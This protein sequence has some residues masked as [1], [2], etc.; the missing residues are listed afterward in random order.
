METTS[1]SKK[2]VGRQFIHSCHIRGKFE[3]SVVIKEKIKFD[4]GSVK[5]NIVTI[6]NPRRS[7]YVTNKRYR[8]YTHKPE[9]E[10]LSKL[11]KYT[12]FDYELDRKVAEVL[13]L[14]F[15]WHSR[16]AL[17]KS[18]YIF[19]ADISIE[20][21]IKMKYLR[22]YPNANLQPTTGFLDIETSIDTN[23]IILISYTYDNVVYTAIL[24]S[25]LFENIGNSRVPIKKDELLRHVKENLATRTNG[26]DFTYNIEIFDHEI[27][28]IAWIAKIIHLSE[29]DYI[30][31]WNMNFDIP[32]I[33]TTI[34]KYNYNPA[35]IFANPNLPNNLKYL[36]YYEDHRDVDHFTL[37]WH[38]LYS[39]CG[40]QFLDS[41]G[42][43]SQCRKTA[44]FRDRYTLDAILEDE[45]GSR[46]LPLISGSH[47]IMQRNHFK[48]YV[49]YNIFDVIGLRLL[50]DQNNDIL[51]MHILSGP[52]PV[53]KFSTS[54]I[55]AT[56]TMYNSLI[57]KGSV[58]SS[59]SN[60]DA[61]IKY[62]SLFGR[63]GG[64]VLQSSRC[65][66]VGIKL[67]I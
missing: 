36:K 25:F 55:R 5:P 63:V 43:Y 16:D 48:D 18:P 24:D 62:D 41:M 30:G 51:S 20:A 34:V 65:E 59:C 28:L 57:G 19:G 13:E 23:Q 50:E 56:N 66:G 39:T 47:V 10:L 31:I 3:S 2:I 54:T 1:D 35:K 29:I 8:N 40:S 45:V 44:G 6:N 64:A 38:W 46:K 49:V 27:K 42:L 7:F 12:C 11:D 17:F 53:S 67:T 26:I 58:L 60:S 22:D 52:T 21:L 61:F 33:L 32:K 37:K 15:G 9:Y 14:G 4:D